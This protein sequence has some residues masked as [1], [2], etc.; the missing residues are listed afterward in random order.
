MIFKK[1]TLF[2]IMYLDQKPFAHFWQ[3]QK[4]YL[5]NLNFEF[6]FW[7]LLNLG[8]AQHRVRKVSKNVQQTKLIFKVSVTFAVKFADFLKI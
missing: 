3:K 6:S 5:N 2:S 8:K 7:R 4:K 1:M